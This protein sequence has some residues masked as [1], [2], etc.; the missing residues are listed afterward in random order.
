MFLKRRFTFLQ[1]LLLL[2]VALLARTAT[3][4]QPAGHV[5]A[6][7][8]TPTS[9]QLHIQGWAWDASNGQPASSLRVTVGGQQLVVELDL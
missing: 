4:A 9:Q 5:D 6:L 2:V 7:V 8:Y 1:L 3:A